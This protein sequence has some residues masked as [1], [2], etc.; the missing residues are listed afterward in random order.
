MLQGWKNMHP[1]QNY[2][3][4]HIDPWEIGSMRLD[5]ERIDPGV[6]THQVP[7]LETRRA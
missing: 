1:R 4:E 2:I 5:D 3:E 7:P 6:M